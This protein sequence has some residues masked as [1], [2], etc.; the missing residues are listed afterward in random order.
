MAVEETR[1][2]EVR[3]KKESREPEGKHLGEMKSSTAREGRI[4]WAK[5]SSHCLK[6]KKQKAMMGM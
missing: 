1:V 2:Y 3:E 5:D 4:A 6:S